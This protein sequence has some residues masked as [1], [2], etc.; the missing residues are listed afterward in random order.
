MT[1]ARIGRNSPKALARIILAEQ[2]RESLGHN[3]GED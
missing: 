1:I 3:E 2:V